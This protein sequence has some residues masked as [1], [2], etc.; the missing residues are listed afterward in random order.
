MG[1]VKGKKVGRPK[2][3]E[4]SLT[5]WVSGARLHRR[6]VRGSYRRERPARGWSRDA[7]L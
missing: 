4:K 1:R 5:C 3:G 2:M 7:V 6:G